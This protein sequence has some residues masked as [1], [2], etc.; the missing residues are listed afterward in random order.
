MNGCV[1]THFVFCEVK[2]ILIHIHHDDAAAT[3][4]EKFDNG[5]ADRTTSDH[6]DVLSFFRVSAVDCV[7]ADRQRFHQRQLVVLKSIANVK[8]VS[9]DNELFAHATV[10]VNAD[11]F[12]VVAAI[13][14]TPFAGIAFW[15]VHVG[16]NRTRVA[17]F[18]IGHAIANFQ[19]LHTQFVARR[20]GELK[21]REFAEISRRVRSANSYAM[22]GN[23]R[24]AGARC[25]RCIDSDNRNRFFGFKRNSFHGGP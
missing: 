12:E 7:A 1:H 3:D 24:F 16:L 20:A 22:H 10:T 19:H 21:E 15:I 2:P 13:R 23:F 9:G 18:D 4:L 6:E 25:S 17:R 8:F 14:S 5:Q 11:D